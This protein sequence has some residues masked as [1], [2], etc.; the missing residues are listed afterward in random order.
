MR[1]MLEKLGRSPWTASV[2]GLIAGKAFANKAFDETPYELSTSFDVP[3]DTMAG[4]TTWAQEILE[5]Y[6]ITTVICVL[7]FFAVAIPVVLVVWKFRAKEGEELPPPKQV[8]GNHTLEIIWTIIPCVL[9]I[10]IAVPTWK[11]I[12][13]QFSDP[14]KNAMVIRAKGYQWW[15]EFE[16]LKAKEGKEGEYEVV[17]QTANEL[18]L[19]EKTP[20]LFHLE[21]G[22]VI[23]S[24]WVPRLSG[25]IDTIPG[26]VNHL[27][28]T[29]PAVKDPNKPGGDYYQGQCAEL[30]GWSHALMR[31]ETIIHTQKEFEAWKE[32]HN[33]APKLM[34][35]SEKRGMKAFAAC[36]QCHGIEGTNWAGK[37]REWAPGAIRG[38]NLSNFGNRRTLGAG[39][40]KNNHANLKQWIRNSSTIKQGSKMLIFEN[41][42]DQQLDDLSAFLRFSTA[43][44]Y[45]GGKEVSLNY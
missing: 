38:P 25:K 39:T 42:S 22:D 44:D 13:S 10:F 31:F 37:D 41:L 2:L 23:H 16:Y 26:Q 6:G 32:A 34:T 9:L 14:P 7:V 33:T 11:A 20:I 35:E 40:R 45:Y 8:H 43:K 15:W 28:F 4:A 18:H 3:M 27:Q 1:R 29:T 21:S 12:F 17:L 5:V 19:P 30:C 36:G 24:F